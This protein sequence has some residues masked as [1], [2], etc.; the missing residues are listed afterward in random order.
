[1]LKLLRRIID[2]GVPEG[3]S[4]ED[5]K[6]IQMSNLGSLMMIL[7][8]IPYIVLC[9]V[10]GWLAVLAELCAL[11]ALL[12]F[13]AFI[14]R[15]GRHLFA[16][17]YFGTLLNIHLVFVTV[18]MGRETLLP[19]LI[20]FTAGGIVTLTR[21]GKT[22][23]MIGGLAG[24]FAT[25]V[26]ALALERSFGPLYDLDPS[27]TTTLR[28]IVEVS[29]FV[30]VVV[31]ALIGRFGAIVAE[32][33]LREEKKRSETLLERVREQDRQ[34]TLFFQ[35]VSH[36]LR[37]PLSLILGPL[38]SL[39]AGADGPL[40]EPVREKLAMMGRNA[41]RLL[42]LISQLLD[43]SRIDAGGEKPR[44]ARGNL[45]E[46]LRT[47]VQA[48]AG[49]AEKRRIRLSART[50]G[51]DIIAVFD[52][53]I[54]EKIV[55]NLLSNAC[56]FTLPGGE[57][58]VSCSMDERAKRARISVK[59]TGV[60]IAREELGRIFERFYQVDGS[61]SRTS[62]GT[63]IGL[64]LVKE[65]VK[66]HGGTVEVASAPEAGSEFTVM[67]PVDGPHPS[68]AEHPLG[69]ELPS[70]AVE[71]TPD[72]GYAALETAGLASLLT[73]SAPGPAL[74]PSES[75]ATILVI[76]D[77]PDM[78]AYIRKGVAPYYQVIE[79][80][81][82]EEGLVR[83]RENLPHLVIC[84]VMMP[85]M[86]GLTLCRTFREEPKLRMVPVI[87]LTAK[88]SQEAIIE[89]LESGA[90]DYI[91]KPFSFDVLLAKIRGLLKREAEQGA[92]ALRDGLTGLLTRAAWEQDAARELSRISR[93]GGSASVVFVDL[94]DFKAV[95]DNHGHKSGDRVLVELAAAV[96]GQLRATDL[97]GRYGGEEFV[98]L[99]PDS[100][101]EAAVKSIERILHR[102][103][104]TPIGDEALRCTFSAG[105]AGIG[106]ASTRS[107]AEYV[108][109]SD[110]AM[111]EAKRKGKNCVV[112]SRAGT[113][114]Q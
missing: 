84:D 101:G 93:T 47:L 46:L 105:V 19:L 13:T 65:L 50:G 8:N 66:I 3:M 78:R 25:Y 67:L 91:T 71:L 89:G 88:V 76:E 14:N 85:H 110:A 52:P 28:S 60:G 9:A 53:E 62:E 48:F 36:E 30:L 4:P 33:R 72:L 32:N 83:A 79:A 77:N 21:R 104:E 35:N 61:P 82:G 44:L 10:Y 94:D 11:N 20:F 23:F 15:R 68:V 16:L 7:V 22:G 40:G 63:G 26:A 95:N 75:R 56:K 1:M 103:R 87:L 17:F 97:V 64:S 100:G 12:F 99:L 80:R 92:L 98:L 18:A 73:E 106:G 42:R 112:L 2:L 29:V 39:L 27:Q 81:S 24:I 102:F 55:S 70:M 37:T 49:H 5:A 111:Y 57:V 113:P 96:T 41:K 86:D 51:A 58:V 43:L 38:E 74:A 31:N 59:D 34:K 114:G 90:V 45:S 107:L 54:V 108:A 69:T 6:Y 109:M